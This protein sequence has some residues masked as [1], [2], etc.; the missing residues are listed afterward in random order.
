MPLSCQE[1]LC[2]TNAV[3]QSPHPLRQPS[4]GC[5]A[6]HGIIMSL[7]GNFTFNNYDRSVNTAGAASPSG[8]A[9][10]RRYSQSQ[11]DEDA[12]QRPLSQSL[13]RRWTLTRRPTNT[14]EPQ[15]RRSSNLTGATLEQR[16]ASQSAA[17]SP[18]GAEKSDVDPE[19]AYEDEEQA[20]R[21]EEVQQLARKFSRASTYSYVGNPFDEGEKG[22]LIDPSSPTFNARAWVKS[23]LKFASQG[24]DRQLG[25]SA[26]FAFKNLNVHGFGA[27]TDYQKSV[28]NVVFEIPGLARRLLGMAKPRRIDILRSFDL[29]VEPGEMLVVL[30]PPGS[31]CSTLLKTIAGETHG[32]VVEETSYMNYQGNPHR[33]DSPRPAHAN[34]LDRDQ[35]GANAQRLSR[36]SNLH[37]G[38]GRSFPNA[39][40]G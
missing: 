30:G 13:S 2:E 19:S 4:A 24:S 35:C 32:F 36:R 26:G 6:L 23:M 22:S 15:P 34:P 37:R 31:G 39:D 27:A 29:L 9:F 21:N 16:R 14:P 12:D 20:A 28:G 1:I 25:R 17:I 10:I 11:A 8:T 5:E 7:V 38:S 33:F 40:C 18:E 3:R